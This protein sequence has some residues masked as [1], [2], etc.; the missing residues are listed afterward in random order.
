MFAPVENKF[1]LYKRKCEASFFGALNLISNLGWK[2]FIFYGVCVCVCVVLC[3]ENESGA[4]LIQACQEKRRKVRM[5]ERK[6]LCG[7]P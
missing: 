7:A 5:C 6:S 1:V 3:V 4:E 2:R